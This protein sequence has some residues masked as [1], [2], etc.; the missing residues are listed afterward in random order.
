MLFLLKKYNFTISGSP[1][2][3]GVIFKNNVPSVSLTKIE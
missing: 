3:K 2:D 1:E